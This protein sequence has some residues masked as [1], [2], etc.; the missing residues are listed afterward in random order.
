MRGQYKRANK[1]TT[2]N[3]TGCS[4]HLRLVHSFFGPPLSLWTEERRSPGQFYLSR[5]RETAA[6]ELVKFQLRWTGNNPSGN[7]R[8]GSKSS[9][10]ME[11]RDLGVDTMSLKRLGDSDLFV[12]YVF[13]QQK[14]DGT[15]SNKKRRKFREILKDRE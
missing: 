2:A 3:N 10:K 1:I 14:C 4:C 11:V 8:G 13:K 7:R 5:D 12:E 9:G 6:S 15:F